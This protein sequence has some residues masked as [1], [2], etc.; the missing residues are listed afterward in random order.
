MNRIFT[1]IILILFLGMGCKDKNAES[2]MDKSFGQVKVD[3]ENKY[4][5]PY[6]GHE[7]LVFKDSLGRELKLA[8]TYFFSPF[9]LD[10]IDTIQNGP[11]AHQAVVYGKLEYI[12]FTFHND[13]LGYN[14]SLQHSVSMR[15]DEDQPLFYDQLFGDFYK[16]GSSNP[17]FFVTFSV[18]TDDRGN[19]LSPLFIY[20]RYT[21]A[22]EL[23]LLSKTFTKVYYRLGTNNTAVYFN[24]ES[25][26]IGF[27]EEGGSLWV[28]DRIE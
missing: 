28:L 10:A 27:R 21:Y 17:I 19:D 22:E 24:Q 3:P 8:S 12:T 1:G 2:C 9:Y 26:F 11:C 6:E 23:T 14:L 15:L 5:L 25:G 7:T 16:S 18:I 13:S 20:E 4:P